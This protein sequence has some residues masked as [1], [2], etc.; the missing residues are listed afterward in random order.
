MTMDEFQILWECGS[1]EEIRLKAAT[2]G[3]D[4]DAWLEANGFR[5]RLSFMWAR[6]LRSR[7]IRL[8]Y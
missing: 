8:G 3:I 7:G 6:I 5:W 1:E 4:A 2:L